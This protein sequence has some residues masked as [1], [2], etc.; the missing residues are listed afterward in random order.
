MALEFKFTCPL[1]AGIHARPASAIEE[2][3]R[4]FEADIALV[5]ERTG[6]PASARSVLAMVGLEIRHHDPCR[7]SFS[8]PD[9]DAA[10]YALS[11]FVRDQL[12]HCDDATPVAAVT[13]AG[14]E[15]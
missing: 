10:L 13:A 12:P 14:G 2:I 4:G 8:G 9:A 6:C 5:N 15:I 1:A 7:L 3:A 11:A